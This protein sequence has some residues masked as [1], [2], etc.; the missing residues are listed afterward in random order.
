MS[1]SLLLCP[2][3]YT[4]RVAVRMAQVK[5]TYA[6]RLI[7]RGKGHRHALLE[8]EFVNRINIGRLLQKP[9]HPNSSSVVVSQVP[10]H[11]TTA[12]ALSVLAE[13]DLEVSVTHATKVWRITPVK[14]LLPT[15]LFK[16]GK[17]L[18]DV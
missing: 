9:T 1:T 4:K 7:R 8:R 18:L 13:E 12:R 11:W 15:K 14:N 2:R 6:P 17:T 16:P 10:G 5:L 3:A